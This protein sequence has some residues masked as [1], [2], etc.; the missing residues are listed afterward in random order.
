LRIRALSW[1]APTRTAWADLGADALPEGAIKEDRRQ[2]EYFAANKSPL[3]LDYLRREVEEKERLVQ[4]NEYWV[5]VV[6]YW[7][8]WPFEVLLLPCHHTLRLPDL[9]ETSKDALADIL[10]RLLVRYDNLFETSF[11]YSMGWHGAPQGAVQTVEGEAHWQL[12]AHF[13]PPLLRSATVKKFM[14]GFEMLSEPQR[15]LTAELAAARLRELPEFH[16][17][18]R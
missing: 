1:A 14:V 4:E 15:D 17:K 7:A 2:R 8:V 11:P 9:D 5:A 13:Y 16:Y 3:L 12:H 6:P 10:K 18:Q